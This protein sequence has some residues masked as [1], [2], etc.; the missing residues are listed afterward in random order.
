MKKTIL[1]IAAA[2]MSVPAFGASDIFLFEANVSDLE[3]S[4]S[5]AQLYERLNEAVSDYCVEL[6][7]APQ[8]EACRT[9]VLAAIVVQFD[10]EALT[11]LHEVATR[12]TGSQNMASLENG[13]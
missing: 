5:V 2:M 10:S 9:E 4:G 13:S 12:A 6:V 1:A 3:N 11:H 8:L 7:D